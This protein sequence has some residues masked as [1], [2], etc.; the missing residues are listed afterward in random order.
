[1]KRVGMFVLMAA[2]AACTTATEEDAELITAPQVD[3]GLEEREPDTCNA[4]ALQAALGQN[5]AV[6]EGLGLDQPVRILMPDS[7]ATQ[8]YN[9]SRV[10]FYVNAEGNILRINCG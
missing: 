3:N 4:E 5:K 6:I 10:N 2:V 9:P 7:I 1:M 8:E